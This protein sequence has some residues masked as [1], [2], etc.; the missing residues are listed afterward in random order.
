MDMNVSTIDG[1]CHCGTVRFRVRLT[2]DRRRL[3]L[4]ERNEGAQYGGND[5]NPKHCSDTA[6]LAVQG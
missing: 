4:R 3:L 1:A 5:D 6:A 2:N